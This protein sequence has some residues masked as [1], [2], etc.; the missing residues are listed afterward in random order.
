MVRKK[1]MNKGIFREKFINRL[2]IYKEKKN[3]RKIIYY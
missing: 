3:R 1:D 2:N